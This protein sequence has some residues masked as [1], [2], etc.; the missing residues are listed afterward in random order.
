[1]DDLMDMPD[2]WPDCWEWYREMAAEYDPHARTQD[3]QRG[4]R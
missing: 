2:P 3:T 1:M 4:T